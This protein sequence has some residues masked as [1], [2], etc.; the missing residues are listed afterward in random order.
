MTPISSTILVYFFNKNNNLEM[1][2]TTKSVV[3][4]VLVLA[5]YNPFGGA[6]GL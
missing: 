1:P 2:A 3:V 4:D 6:Y 5:A